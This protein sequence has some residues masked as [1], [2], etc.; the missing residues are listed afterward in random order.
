MVAHGLY[1]QE[2][3]RKGNVDTPTK[4]PDQYKW[5]WRLLKDDEEGVQAL[6]IVIINTAIRSQIG[7]IV[8]L[9]TE[10]LK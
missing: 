3:K 10:Q 9:Y 8:K 2:G 5:K 6:K 4:D 1:R 7:C